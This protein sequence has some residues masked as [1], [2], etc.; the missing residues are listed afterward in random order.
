MS[1]PTKFDLQPLTREALQ[2]IVERHRCDEN[3]YVCVDS[4]AGATTRREPPHADRGA[5]IRFLIS[6]S[7]TQTCFCED[8][9]V[10]GCHGA[11]LGVLR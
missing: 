5:L 3:A 11:V 9:H 7:I 1:A 8:S 4:L 10:P 2:A 6:M